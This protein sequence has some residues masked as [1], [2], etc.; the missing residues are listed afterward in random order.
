MGKGFRDYVRKYRFYFH[1][2]SDWGTVL[3]VGFDVG[4]GLALG[5]VADFLL[6]IFTNIPKSMKE[7]SSKIREKC[8]H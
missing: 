5:A 7:K 6:L 4:N 1:S 8:E 3:W 2:K